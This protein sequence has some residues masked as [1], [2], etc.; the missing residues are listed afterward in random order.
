MMRMNLS[1]SDW[2]E[3]GTRMGWMKTA[4]STAVNWRDIT[5]RYRAISEKLKG[6]DPLSRATVA[7]I[8]QLRDILR[9]MAW[10][11]GS[12]P[13]GEFMRAMN[14]ATSKLLAVKDSLLRSQ[15]DSFDGDQ[16]GSRGQVENAER[17]LADSYSHIIEAHKLR[18]GGG[19]DMGKS[20][21][22]DTCWEG[23]TRRGTKM[24]GGRRVPNC[25]PV[26]GKKR[27]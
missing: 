16:K 10:G 24:K 21:S 23:Y 2:V 27:S 19:A 17:Y 5:A 15:D 22:G 4:E 6:P 3:I 1:R 13:G 8:D 7:Y 14:D 26:D 11:D 20:A 12:G 25:V 18:V 9:D